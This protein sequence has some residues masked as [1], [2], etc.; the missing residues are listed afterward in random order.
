MSKSAAPTRPVATG[1][2]A[3]FVPLTLGR[4][5]NAIDLLVPTA[6]PVTLPTDMKARC[7]NYLSNSL[8]QYT[9]IYSSAK[10]IAAFHHI[11]GS[12][13]NAALESGALAASLKST[14]FAIPNLTSLGFCDAA[15]KL[16]PNVTLNPATCPSG[17]FYFAFHSTVNPT[18]INSDLSLAVTTVK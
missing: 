12:T 17:I 10:L 2:P 7:F 15:G 5:A 9:T 13:H 8:F 16:V 6:P 3:T 18:H 11:P 14:F 4:T 1:N